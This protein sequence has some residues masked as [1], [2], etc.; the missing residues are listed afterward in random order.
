MII[1]KLLK[2]NGSLILQIE[3]TNRKNEIN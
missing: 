1:K 3:L 2:L